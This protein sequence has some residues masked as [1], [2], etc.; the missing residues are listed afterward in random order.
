MRTHGGAIV[1]RVLQY[2]YYTG[3]QTVVVGGEIV[4]EILIVTM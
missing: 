4:G 3:A 1:A 2:A